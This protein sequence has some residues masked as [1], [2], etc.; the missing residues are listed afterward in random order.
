MKRNIWLL[1]ALSVVFSM[2]AT[3]CVVATPTPEVVEKVVT[4]EV[5]VE[6]EVVVTATPE[7]AHEKVYRIVTSEPRTGVDPAVATTARS[8]RMTELMHDPLFARDRDNKPVVPWASDSWE[9]SDDYTVYKFHIRDGL[10][11][12]DGS[13]LTVE[14][15]MFSFER[16]QASDLW[17]V[18]LLAVK[19]I[20]IEGD[21]TIVLTMDRSFPEFM[22]LP[23]W[24]LGYM[25]VS[26][27]FCEDGCDLNQPGAVTSGPYYLEE[28][29]PKSHAVLRKNP[30]Y[31]MEGYP[32]FDK[33][34]W[35][36]STDP[37]AS[38]AA[39][40]SG[41]ADHMM[42]IPAAEVPR[43]RQT[44]GVTVH[45]AA[46]TDSWRGF[47]FDK[48]KPP[49]SDK[50]VR[51]AF[52]YLMEP[53]EITEACWYG[54]G[55]T[56]YGGYFYEKDPWFKN[57][58]QEPWKG[59]AREERVEIAKGLLREAGWWDEDGDGIA[60]SHGV[61]GIPDATKLETNC[62]YESTWLQS[63]CHVLL[64]SEWAK[65]AGFS[66]IPDRWE[67]GGYW[68]D[69]W[70]DKHTMWHAARSTNDSPW[71]RIT[72]AFRSDGSNKP[73][74]MGGSF[75]D[76]ELDA[77][78]DEMNYEGDMEKKIQLMSDIVDYIVDQQYFV[79]TGSQDQVQLTTD[80]LINFYITSDHSLRAL[81]TAD[82]PG[83]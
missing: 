75:E 10:R 50:R 44:P 4:Q 6:K 17:K 38:V 58:G 16:M 18:R 69:V 22:D 5:E 83:R 73:N 42:P 1:M 25:I 52:G 23:G 57:F 61:E 40:E 51:Q 27:A 11:F 46:A 9:I 56:L 33:I 15:V 49:F 43:L 63:E 47:G 13:P 3:Q 36:F 7:P 70:A 59:L 76:P 60:E 8:M 14:D 41:A 82:I 62:V 81:I 39:V 35:T 77:M 31:W 65:D 74:L 20:E 79:A 67:T 30:Y 45:Y 54:V 21:D 55:S 2:V 66:I 78:I 37:L 53:E 12:T 72:S 34:E 68:A 64:A 80:Q 32:T 71:G 19:S 26:K 29:V 24:N 48:S 28:Y